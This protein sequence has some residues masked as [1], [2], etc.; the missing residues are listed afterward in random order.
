LLGSDDIITPVSPQD[1]LDRAERGYRTCQHFE[2]GAHELRPA[3]WPKWGKHRVAMGAHS[4]NERLPEKRRLRKK[5]WNHMDA[6]SI[7]ARVGRSVWDRY[8][9]F[10]IERNPRD[11]VVS[12]F[13]DD[14][15]RRSVD[16]FFGREIRL[17]GFT[18]D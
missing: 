18:F 17:M 13:Y 7:R 2:K 11:K 15:T 3:E 1:G 12:R 16:I 5:C 9:K 8:L 10:T 6:A 4:G 14:W